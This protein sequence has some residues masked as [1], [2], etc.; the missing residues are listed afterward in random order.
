MNGTVFVVNVEIEGVFCEILYVLN[1]YGELAKPC[2]HWYVDG[3]CEYC[4][5]CEH[6]SIEVE[7]KDS[8]CTEAGYKYERCTQCGEI[9]YEEYYT[10]TEHQYVDGWCEFCGAEEKG[11]IICEKHK[12]DAS[13]ICIFCGYYKGEGEDCKHV[14]LVN[15]QMPSCT[16]PGYKIEICTVCNAIL[17]QEILPVTGHM[18]DEKGYCMYCGM[19]EG[20][21]GEECA[22]E[23]TYTER[24]A[25]TCTEYGYVR[26]I[27]DNCQMIIKDNW[28]EPY[29]HKFDEMGNCTNCGY[30]E[31][32]GDFP[33]DDNGSE[34]EYG[35]STDENG[36]TVVPGIEVEIPK[37]E[38]VVP[39]G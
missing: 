17:Y 5:K 19:Y 39:V 30:S 26:V 32:N 2:D 15:E 18:F 11:D 20:D 27:C 14:V 7:V 36:S 25:A 28:T 16:E 22:H 23:K 31:G 34:G 33:E 12:F 9:V 35:E 3:W 10:T 1:E 4:G 24:Q 13:G 21:Y 38:E 37:Y 6:S 29:G 8:T